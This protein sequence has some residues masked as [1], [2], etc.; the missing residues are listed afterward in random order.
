MKKIILLLAIIPA[1]VTT[2]SCT[3]AETA[4]DGTEVVEEGD[5]ALTEGTE[6]LEQ[7]EGVDDATAAADQAAND[8]A[9]LSDTLG[10][11]A[12]PTAEEAPAPPTDSEPPP[13][14]LVAEAPL[15]DTP[16][17][18]APPLIADTPPADSFSAVD[19]GSPATDAPPEL[20]PPSE[21]APEVAAAPSFDEPPKPKASLKKVESTPFERGGQLLNAVYVARPSDSYK[22]ISKMIYGS[23]DRWRDIK[24]ANPSISKPKPGNKIYYNSPVRADDRTKILTYYEDLG[25][26]PEVYVSKDGDNI[27]NISK[28]LL[29]YDNAWQEIWATNMVESK[30]KIPA[31]TELRYWKAAPAQATEIAQN[32]MPADPSMGTAA[33][34]TGA[35]SMPPPPPP[36]PEMPPPPPPMEA[37]APPPPPIDLP[38]P[39][40][41]A[42]A[43]NPPPPPPM[44]K[45]TKKTEGMGMGDDLVY[46][47][48]AGGIALFAVGILMYRKRKQQREMSQ[49]FSDTQVGM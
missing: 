44:A 33:G 48:A 16:P 5:V 30:G 22:S 18:D 38:P 42:E 1:L 6:N 4:E 3:S 10:E 46:L 25:M 12:P 37:S 11:S 29:G 31:G 20:T 9:T 40:P 15:T 19:P 39:P 43:L 28:D 32:S 45:K 35:N 17:A 23:E 21:P 24:K 8:S 2:I 7:V 13:N 47:G 49:A 26:V 36:M 41:P 14:D 34:M 27:R